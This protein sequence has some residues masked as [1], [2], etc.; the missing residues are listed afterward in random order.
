MTGD[1]VDHG[2]RAADPL[3]G[4]VVRAACLPSSSTRCARDLPTR[5]TPTSP[6]TTSTAALRVG[7]RVCNATIRRPYEL[8]SAGAPALSLWDPWIA[9]Q[10]ARAALT[11]N[12]D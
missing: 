11:S 3:F 2:V 1:E 8:R 9:E 5:S 10:L 12:P 6:S 4:E 7:G